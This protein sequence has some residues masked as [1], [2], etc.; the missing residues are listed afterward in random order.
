MQAAAAAGAPVVA[1][2][3]GSQCIFPASAGEAP[4]TGTFARTSGG[5]LLSR[6]GARFAATTEGGVKVAFTALAALHACGVY[7]GDA[8]TANLL[9]VDGQAQ[10]IDMRACMEEAEDGGALPL[11]QQQQRDALHLARS[12]LFPHPLPPPVEKAL[13]LYNAADPGAV[14]AL[15]REVCGG[16]VSF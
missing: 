1:P 16:L 13:K 8:R 11:E 2:V 3:P 5:Y 9:V 4:T 15:V 12:L 14:D 10:W 6:V 7:H